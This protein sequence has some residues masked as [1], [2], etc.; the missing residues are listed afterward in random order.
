METVM[1]KDKTAVVTGGAQGI[2]KQIA[3]T[4]AREGADVA[5]CDIDEAALKDVSAQ[6][7]SLG[8]R[9]F[10]FTVDVRNTNAVG[11]TVNKIIDSLGR[12][13]ILVNN[14]GITRDG[15]LVRMS[16]GDWDAVL[17]VNLKGVFNFTKAVLRP[18]MKR[19]TGAIINISSVVGLAGN[20]GQ[21]NY[22]ASKAGVIGLTKSVAKEAAS[23]S[24]RVN[25]IAPGMIATQMT[26]SLPEEAKQRWLS[27]IPMGRMGNPMDVANAA[28]FLAS[29]LAVY[30][31]GQ[32]IVVDG[33]MVM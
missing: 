3:L 6:I 13:D 20:A 9:S 1:L 15:L 8:R 10:A 31:T 19:R 17:A 2:G 29:D 4:F 18:M 22:S 32:V 14:A 30:I 28:L 12:I 33:G 11:E 24:V 26:K 5:L 23:R 21:V 16:E 7:E 27:N 25:A